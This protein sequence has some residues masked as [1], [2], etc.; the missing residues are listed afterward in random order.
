MKKRN[1][2]RDI[3]FLF[4]L[5]AL[6]WAATGQIKAYC[7]EQASYRCSIQ[8]DGDLTEAIVGQ[9]RGLGGILRFEPVDTMLVT[10]RLE[11]YVLETELSGVDLESYPLRFKSVRASIAICNT[12]QLFLGK[13]MFLMFTD[14]NGRS[15]GNSQIEKWIR[16]YPSL[17]LFVTDENGCERKARACGILE[18]PDDMI[19]MEKGQM[20][21]VFGKC[22]HVS[23]GFLEIRGNSNMEKACKLLK[24]AGFA[25]RE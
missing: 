1:W 16:E 18:S 14:K 23:G 11:T 8:S 21:E 2:Y 24:D 20:E 12:P 17:E 22:A 13:E 7:R 10:I 6:A 3:V 9:M 15:P 5:C 19:C 25:V 4:A